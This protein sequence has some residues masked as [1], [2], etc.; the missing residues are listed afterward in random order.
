[1]NTTNTLP[2]RHRTPT[3]FLG[4]L[5]LAT[6][7][8]I[9]PPVA[10]GQTL[11]QALNTTNLTWTTSGHY[12]GWS[13]ETSA[14]HDGVSAAYSGMVYSINTSTLQTTVTGPGT[15]TFWWTNPSLYNR[16][17]F[18]VGGVT[19]T[20]IIAYSSSWQQ[21][22]IYLGSGSQT[23][24]WVYSVF[25]SPGDSY[26]G[27]VDQVSYTPGSTAP[28]ITAQ[29]T[30]QSQVPGCNV[31]FTVGTGGT[32][33][34]YYQWRFNG[35]NI[36]DATAS[37]YTVTNVQATSLGD[38]SVMVTN[39]V[40]SVISSNASLGFAQIT[41]WGSPAY[42][43]TAIQ[44]GASNV[45]AIAAGMYC[46][47]LLNPD[48]TVSAWGDNRRGQSNVPAILTN[49]IAIACYAHNLALKP[50]GT[51]VAWGGS[52][53]GE[54][55]VP[56]GLSNIV[57]I[58]AGRS[59][60][61]LALKSDG[62][63]AAWG[64]AFDNETNVPAGLTNVVA[65]AA[66][67]GYDVALKADGTLTTWGK[68]A[69]VVPTNLSNV[70]AIA[71]GLWHAVALLANGTVVAWGDN[72]YRETSVPLGLTN[73]AAIAAGDMHTLALLAN[74]TLVAWGYNAYGQTN[75][76][77]GL[78]NVV[79]ISAGAYHNLAQVGSGP[80]VLCAPVINPTLSGSG[81]SLTLSS[82]SG[83]VYALEYK[84]NLSDAN[85]VSLPLTAGTGTNLALLDSTATNAQRFYRVR[86][87]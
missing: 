21:Q 36:S 41:A 57:A 48:G 82:Q 73:V 15:L 11:A 78:T 66:G 52:N 30:S 70:V 74:G 84:A 58:A 38:Y 24:Q 2:L 25:T 67:E 80:P 53:S 10:Q 27:Y 17:S 1:M 7:L 34:L 54:T 12:G 31:T 50:D 56:A 77:P 5:A 39:S 87:W 26:Y 23:L 37:A 62:S 72:T 71:A 29:P 19:W 46:N 40:N 83:R 85:W 63:L 35:T 16:L 79:A 65:I 75:V 55:N 6:A 22:T 60:H 9:T 3:Q 47:L 45:L 28:L 51:I 68:S 64:W 86:R 20:Y 76:P 4:L 18:I 14:T 59:P 81:F 32:P 8:A 13:S 44:T 42:G 33:P 43:A 49:A 69:P 61:S